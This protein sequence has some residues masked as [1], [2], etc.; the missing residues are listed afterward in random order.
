[1]TTPTPEDDAD[2]RYAEYVLGV[3]D[4]DAR[5]AVEQQL[6][7]SSA[8]AAAEAQWR[9][10]LLP[11]AEEVLP[12][13]PPERLWQRIRTALEFDAPAARASGGLWMNLR[14]WHWLTLGSGALLAAA[15]AALV[16]M[17]VNR[18]PAP[19]I[20]YMAA[21]ITET[22]GQ[23]GW[24]ATMDI[25]K[26]RMIVVPAAPQPVRP[27]R[28]PELWLIPRGG[29]PIAVG[30]ISTRTPITL[31]LSASLIERLGPTARLAVSIEPRGGS[32]TGQP[33]GPVIGAGAIGAAS[34]A[35]A[36]ATA[37][38]LLSSPRRPA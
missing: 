33:T 34:A 15:C 24:T 9:R 8:A 11:L 3:L 21:A 27:G 28:T 23:V 17:L 19:P 36:P 6:A 31:A 10:R 18:P 4:A 12:Q 32:P 38:R 5:A 1:M 2:L 16:F 14:L 25:G 30:L 20:P 37:L 35:P 13:M 7:S 26:A 29:R 22:D